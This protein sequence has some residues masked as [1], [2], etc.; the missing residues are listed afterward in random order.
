MAQP[1][2]LNGKSRQIN[3][4]HTVSVDWGVLLRRASELAVSGEFQYLYQIE[5]R[6]HEEGLG[7]VERTFRRDPN[8]RK[9]LRAMIAAATRARSKPG[10]SL[11]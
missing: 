5:R 4:R 8:V 1:R 11:I 3:G 6:L 7:G 2:H 9:R 10:R